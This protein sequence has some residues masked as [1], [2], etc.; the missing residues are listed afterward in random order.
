[1]CEL[2]DRKPEITGWYYIT[3]CRTCKIPMIVSTH[4]KPEFTLQER[5]DIERM[6][7]GRRVRWEMRAIK[8]HAHCHVEET[9]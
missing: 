3:L 8:D 4:H 1:M 7:P 2:C 9:I 6:F 5:T